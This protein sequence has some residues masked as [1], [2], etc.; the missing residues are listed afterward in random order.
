MD[1]KIGIRDEV[2]YFTSTLSIEKKQKRGFP[3]LFFAF[4]NIK[5]KH[6]SLFMITFVE[7]SLNIFI[8]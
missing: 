4:N 8:N 5:D 3:G 2:L 7:R 6:H 1:R